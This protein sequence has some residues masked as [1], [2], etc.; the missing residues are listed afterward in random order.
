MR[1]TDSDRVFDE[2]LVISVRAGNRRAAERLAARWHPRLV[3]TATRFLGN[4]DQ[5]QDAAQEAWAAMSAAWVRLDDPRKFAGWAFSILHRK[6]SDIQRRLI[7]D[8]DGL[9]ELTLAATDS[10]QDA[11]SDRRLVINDAFAGLKPEH[12]ATAILFFA[13]GLTLI[14]IAHITGAPIGTVKSRLFHAR[15]QLKS[16]LER[17]NP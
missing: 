13:E 14:E 11:S 7:K 17:E 10:P 8:R 4:A 6:C 16:N 5:G 2:L 1:Y 9:S 3:R 12:R 15:Q